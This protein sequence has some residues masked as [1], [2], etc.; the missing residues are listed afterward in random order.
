MENPL[1]TH[2]LKDI[3]KLANADVPIIKGAIVSY[4]IISLAKKRSLS[5]IIIIT[6]TIKNL[7]LLSCV[8]RSGH[9]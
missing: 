7:R 9:D 8:M 2:N 5:S 3:D 6:N 4:F 1:H